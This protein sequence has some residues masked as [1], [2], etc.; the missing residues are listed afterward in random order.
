[1]PERRRPEPRTFVQVARRPALGVEVSTGRA[2]VGVDQQVGHGSAD[3]LFALTDEQYAAAL[4]GEGLGPFEGE[5]WRGEHDDLLLFHPGGGSWTPERWSPARS[6]MLPT[7]FEGELWWHLDALGEPADSP[8][9]TAARALA[10][11]T[12]TGTGATA[13]FRLTGD[14]A[15]PRPAALIGGLG[16]G[17]DRA[18]ARAVLGE[19]L[20][21]E[22]DVHAVEGDLVRLGY[23][24][25]GLAVVTL[26]RP[27]PRPL[28]AGPLGALLAVVGEPERGPAFRAAAPLAD[29]AHRRW[30]VSSGFTRRLLAFADGTEVQVED[31]RVLSVRRPAA[32]LDPFP[33][34]GPPSATVR[35]TGLYRFGDRDLLVE[36]A[37]DGTPRALT[38]VLRGVS[39]SSGLHRWRSG[40]FTLFL[41]V[42]DRP[43][44]HPLVAHVRALPGVRLVLRRGLVA[45]AVIGDRGHR[46]ERFAAFVDGMP[47]A[48]A[49]ADVPFGR[50]DRRGGRDDLRAFAQGW[51]HVHCPDGD[52]VGTV[53]V[54]RQPPRID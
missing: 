31:G 3:A 43:E 29:G 11:G 36:R 4:A 42:L 9:A 47:A 15:Y 26:E 53:A 14:G 8:P 19:P 23:A 35:D 39:V 54:T 41:D 34:L 28:P 25:G 17:S 48:P 5:C 49:R 51:I 33:V 38:A 20:A 45:E 24:D 2:W 12:D 32:A 7:R 1:M 27:A 10:A 22:G 50:P 52:T 6:R 37:A 13:V 30:A 46:A 16:P 44:S 18:R 21:A 40:E